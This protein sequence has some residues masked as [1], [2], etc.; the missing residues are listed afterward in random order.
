MRKLIRTVMSLAVATGVA[1]LIGL[2]AAPAQADPIPPAGLTFFQGTFSDGQQVLHIADPDG[3]CTPFP[4]SA[5]WLVGTHT[6]Q[7]V[8]A[9]RT[10][11]CDGQVIALGNLATFGAGEFLSFR[12]I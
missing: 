2:N 11:D 4:A 5:T 8:L 12:A 10:A 3:T 1:A 6:F 9:Y 7:D